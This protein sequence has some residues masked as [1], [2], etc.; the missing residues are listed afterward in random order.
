MVR[1]A[2][3]LGSWENAGCV[4]SVTII[5]R[6]DSMPIV[7]S[8]KLQTLNSAQLRKGQGGQSGLGDGGDG[9]GSSEGGLGLSDCETRK[10]FSVHASVK[11][12]YLTVM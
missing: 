1:L 6:H 10:V 9:E 5:T 11:L 12:S 8:N 7:S 4:S 2:S 3:V